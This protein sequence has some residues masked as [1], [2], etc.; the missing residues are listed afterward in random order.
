MGEKDSYRCEL[1]GFSL[2]RPIARF[3]VSF[4]GLYDDSRFPGRCILVLQ[5]HAERWESLPTALL[6]DFVDDSQIAMKAI[7]MATN[8]DR[9]NM[10][11]LGNT[12]A[13]VHY[14]L[15][16]RI[17]KFEPNPQRSPWSDPRPHG[18]LPE[19][20]MNVIENGIAAA[21]TQFLEIER[22]RGHIVVSS[23]DRHSNRFT[24]SW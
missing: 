18:H 13:H 1:C 8:C 17:S 20:E 2:W 7:S 22:S 23:H 14:H 16:P 3:G 5:E 11:V 21:L 6:H 12:D 10:A 24:Y 9:V 4:L 15:I 19:S